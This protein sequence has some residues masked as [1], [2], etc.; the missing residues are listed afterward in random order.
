MTSYQETHQLTDLFSAENEHNF[1][2]GRGGTSL[3][4]TIEQSLGPIFDYF[5]A[6]LKKKDGQMLDIRLT[7]EGN[8]VKLQYGVSPVEKK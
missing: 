4:P 8:D 7:V 1:Q 5:L 2:T 6:E 3:L